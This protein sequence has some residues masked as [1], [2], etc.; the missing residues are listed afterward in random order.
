[1]YVRE[2]AKLHAWFFDYLPFA[3]RLMHMSFP[4]DFVKNGWA[5]T[6]TARNAKDPSPTARPEGASAAPAIGCF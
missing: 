2:N 5:T 3:E 1:M 6:K 4:V